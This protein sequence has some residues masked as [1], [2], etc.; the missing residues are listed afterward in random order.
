ML[1]AP[2]GLLPALEAVS[3]LMA[4]VDSASADWWAARQTARSDLVVAARCVLGEPGPPKG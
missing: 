4:H 2:Q 3:E 1:A